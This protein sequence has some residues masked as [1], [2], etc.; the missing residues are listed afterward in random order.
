M[1]AIIVFANHIY[2]IQC[3]ITSKDDIKK[4]YAEIEK[5][6]KNGIHLLVNNAGVAKDDNTKY[7]NSK[8]DM[9]SAQAIADHMWKSDPDAWIETMKTNLVG[10]YFMSAAFLPLLDRAR[11]ATPGYSPSVV[12]ITSISGLMKG[13]SGGQFA[14]STSKAAAIQLTRN[15]ATT[16]SDCKIRVNSIAPGLFPSEMTAGPSNENNKSELKNQSSN[17]AGRP[18]H[19]TD[20]AACILFLAGPGGVFLNGQIIHPD[21]GKWSISS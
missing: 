17:P 16:F 1:Y 9:S 15:L 8:P 6:E 5:N 13:S 12:N 11:K 20:M 7:S 19:D 18:G 2:R 10:H 3:D 21:G 14:Y 4:A